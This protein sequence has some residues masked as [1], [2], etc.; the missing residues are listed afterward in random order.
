MFFLNISFTK[1]KVVKTN[2]RFSLLV[3]RVTESSSVKELDLKVA[4]IVE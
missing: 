1:E 4:L 2:P 3:R